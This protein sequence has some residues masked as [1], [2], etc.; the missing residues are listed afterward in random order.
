MNVAQMV[1]RLVA[2]PWVAL[3]V[4]LALTAGMPYAAVMRAI[5]QASVT[6]KSRS[7]NSLKADDLISRHPS[8]GQR[9][10]WKR[11]RASE[12]AKSS[13]LAHC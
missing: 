12:L 2:R 4:I 10:E 5:A 13:R 7:G 9:F 6:M 8:V 1:G 3:V 11:G